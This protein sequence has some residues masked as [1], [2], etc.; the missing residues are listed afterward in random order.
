[1]TARVGFIGAALGHQAITVFLTNDS[2]LRCLL[3]GYPRVQMLTAG[4]QRIPT[5]TDTGPSYTIPPMRPGRVLLSRNES[6]TFFVGITDATGYGTDSC[7]VSTWVAITLPRDKIPIMLKMRLS[8]Y[9][10]IVQHVRCGQVSVS[11]VIAG[12]H[13]RT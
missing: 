5:E 13:R 4:S 8:A 12:V 7:P 10:G 3:D 9:G 6:A 1:M 11:P 2:N